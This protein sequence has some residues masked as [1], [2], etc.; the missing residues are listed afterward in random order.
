MSSHFVDKERSFGY[1]PKVTKQFLNEYKFNL[2][3]RLQSW[4]HEKVLG[5]FIFTL[6]LALLLLLY[7]AGYF[8]PYFPLTINIIVVIALILAII[9]LNL[10][11]KFVFSTVIFFWVLT[12]IFLILD[13]DVWAERAAIYAFDTFVIGLILLV[14]KKNSSTS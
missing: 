6:M 9:L 5:I 8:A 3:S 1:Y 7:S 2:N 14:A 12:S 11:S 10:K 4:A 13:I